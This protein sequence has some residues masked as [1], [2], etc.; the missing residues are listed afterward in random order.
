MSHDFDEY[1]VLLLNN[2]TTQRVIWKCL[3]H[4]I[5]PIGIVKSYTKVY[6]AI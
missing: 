2:G 4:N 3:K 1:E 6:C 5:L